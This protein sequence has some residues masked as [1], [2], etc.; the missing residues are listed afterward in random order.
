MDYIKE[1][2]FATFVA[3][4]SVGLF[5]TSMVILLFSIYWILNNIK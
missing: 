2:L 1:A 3:L 5:I 4:G